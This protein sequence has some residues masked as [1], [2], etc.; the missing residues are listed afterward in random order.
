MAM[1]AA[2]ALQRPACHDSPPS[3]ASLTPAA[4]LQDAIAAFNSCHG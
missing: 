1:L 2:A 4:R 3:F